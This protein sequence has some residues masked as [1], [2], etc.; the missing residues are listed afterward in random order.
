MSL[1]W[2]QAVAAGVITQAEA[3]TFSDCVK[4]LGEYAYRCDAE[5]LDDEQ[6]DRLC[7]A[8]SW[9]TSVVGVH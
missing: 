3:D 9:L 7:T 2:D 4:H 8:L 6:F 1:P 5:G